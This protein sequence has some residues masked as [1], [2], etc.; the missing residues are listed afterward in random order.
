MIEEKLEIIIVTYNRSKDLEN[1]FQQLLKSPFAICKVTILDNNSLDETPKICSKYQKLFP[2][3]TIIRHPKNIGANPNILRAIELSNSLY[4]WVLCDDDIYDF[5]D[6]SDVIGAIE[7]EEYDIISVGMPEIDSDWKRGISTTPNE[8][9]KN[10]SRFFFIMAFIP[11]TIFK[12]ELFDSYCLHKGYFHAHNKLP[13]FEFIKKSIEDNFSIYLSKKL[14]I[15]RG[16][17]NFTPYSILSFLLAQMDCSLGIKNKKIRRR[18]ISDNAYSSLIKRIILGIILE[19][20]RTNSEERQ[21]NIG[22]LI[23]TFMMVFGFS[24]QQF[25]LLIMIP[26]ILIPRFVYMLIINLVLF[27][28]YDL[29]GRK[30]P[31]NIREKIVEWDKTTDY[32]SN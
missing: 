7:S 32:L 20:T 14:I 22:L 31:D 18:F 13:T 8:L 6:C 5:S 16:I 1:T 17:H 9:L 27:L 19:K 23:P 21:K 28:K 29:R 15:N 12:T 3:I 25:I 24:R 11:A 10:D 4:T 26:M 30:T 2:N